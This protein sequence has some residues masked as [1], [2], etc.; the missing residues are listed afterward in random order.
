MNQVRDGRNRF[1]L[2]SGSRTEQCA[3]LD[4]KTFSEKQLIKASAADKTQIACKDQIVI[5]RRSTCIPEKGRYGIRRSRCCCQGLTI[6]NSLEK[7]QKPH[8]Y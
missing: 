7:A 4:I 3:C 8:N 2:L 1:L 5:F 6:N